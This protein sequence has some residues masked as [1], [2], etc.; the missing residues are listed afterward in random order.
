MAITCGLGSAVAWRQRRSRRP[1]M[2]VV[3][4]ELEIGAVRMRFEFMHEA[5]TRRRRIDAL[6]ILA[7]WSSAR[8]CRQVGV[9]GW[10]YS[11]PRLATSS[12][13]FREFR[14]QRRRRLRLSPRRPVHR[15]CAP[16]RCRNSSNRRLTC[17]SARSSVGHF[18]QDDQAARVIEP[19]RRTASC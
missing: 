13:R 8:R 3:G 1:A 7:R 15:P 10:I 2:S 18:E 9:L 4:D 6:E 17:S 16:N 11:Q 19:T 12:A 14:R 5:F